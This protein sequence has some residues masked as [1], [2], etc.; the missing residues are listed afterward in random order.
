MFRL[1]GTKIELRSSIV[2]WETSQTTWTVSSIIWLFHCFRTDIYDVHF[3]IL[4]HII[5]SNV[6]FVTVMFYL[7]SWSGQKDNLNERIFSKLKIL[8]S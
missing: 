1:A 3:R 4:P 2:V 7:F 5:I 6:L 8:S